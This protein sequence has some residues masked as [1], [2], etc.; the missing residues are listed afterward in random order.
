MMKVKVLQKGL[1]VV[2]CMLMLSVST[3]LAQD[4]CDGI[5]ID[6]DGS[7]VLRPEACDLGDIY[8][9]CTLTEEACANDG[10]CLQGQCSV[11]GGGCTVEA[12]CPTGICSNGDPCVDDSECP[13]WSPTCILSQTCDPVAQTCDEV[14]WC[15][16]GSPVVHRDKALL[17]SDDADCNGKCQ[18]GGMDCSETEPCPFGGCILSGSTCTDY[19]TCEATG[20]ACTVNG[21][22]EGEVCEDVDNCPT[23]PN[24]GQQNSDGDSFGDAC[25]NCPTVS[26]ENQADSDG[27]GVGDACEAAPPAAVPTLGEWGMIIFMTIILGLGVATLLRRRR[28]T[29]V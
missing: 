11:T 18:F 9:Q 27:D 10:D 25:D 19:Y 5:D 12:D 22:C 16:G 23:T 3:V 26:N 7:I 21:D 29:L 24:P 2:V 15:V 1:V 8:G 6:G 14:A 4:P 20:A 13:T 17:C 28:T